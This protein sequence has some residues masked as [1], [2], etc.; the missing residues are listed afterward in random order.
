L[1]WPVNKWDCSWNVSLSVFQGNCK[2]LAAK[3]VK[4]IDIVL[5]G[6][7]TD[8]PESPIK[9]CVDISE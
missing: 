3:I 7:S 5:N 8:K 9:L 4:V 1:Q 6:L 2:S